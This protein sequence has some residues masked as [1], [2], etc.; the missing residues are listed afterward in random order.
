[1]PD[2]DTHPIC[3]ACAGAGCERCN[4]LGFLPRPG[5]DMPPPSPTDDAPAERR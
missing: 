1:M 4:G 3:P 5:A 2:E